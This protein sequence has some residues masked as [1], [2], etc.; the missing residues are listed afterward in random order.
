MTPDADRALRQLRG[1]LESGVAR[2]AA[3]NGGLVPPAVLEGLRRS[4]EHRLVRLERRLV[5]GVKRRE[6]EMMGR[7][8][9]ARG[10]LYPHGVRQERQLAFIPFLARYGQA[11]VDE[12]IAA[13]RVHARSLVSGAPAVSPKPTTPPARV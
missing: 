1:D 8:A 10:S 7:I 13:A 3:V 12:M 6:T 11:L 5:A 9:R 2:L 4:L